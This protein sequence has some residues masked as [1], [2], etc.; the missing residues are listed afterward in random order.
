[1]LAVN[2]SYRGQCI[3]IAYDLRCP[4][5]ADR[6][7]REHAAWREYGKIEVLDPNH[8]VLVVYAG[9]ARRLTR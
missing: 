6:L 3:L 4:D 5:A 8:A 7:H 9:G 2:H 1:M